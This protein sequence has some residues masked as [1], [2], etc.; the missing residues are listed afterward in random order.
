MINLLQLNAESNSSIN[1][2]LVYAKY[3]HRINEHILY[4]NI[5]IGNNINENN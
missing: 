2:I 4:I 5:I 3:V 1:Y